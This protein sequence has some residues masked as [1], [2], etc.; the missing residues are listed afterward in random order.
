MELRHYLR[1]ARRRW[2]IA[3]VGM[4]T[5]ALAAFI[6]SRQLPPIYE[7]RATLLLNL[8]QQPSLP[9]YNDVSA[10]QALTKT[11][12]RLITSRP[13]LE[14]T[15]RRIGGAVTLEDLKRVSGTSE[16]QTQ[17][18]YVTFRHQDPALATT[19]VNTVA[20]V[21]AERI[22]TAQIGD[23]AP[24]G[25]SASPSAVNTIFI[26]DPAR[27][28]T[29]P[30]LPKV[31]LNVVLAMVAGLAIAIGIIAV[32]EYLD[33]AV[34]DAGDLQAIGLPLLGSLRQAGKRRDGA[35]S[36]LDDKAMKSAV[37]EDYRQLRTNLDFVAQPDEIRNILIT[38]VQ[39]ADGKTTVLCNLAIVLANTGRRVIVV[40]C[41]LRKPAVH[42]FFD[43]PN[44]SGLT[45]LFITDTRKLD[46]YLK[47][48]PVENLRILTSGP[49]TPP[50]PAQNLASPRMADIMS[51]L[52]SM[53]D[54]VL[55]DAPPVLGFS[56]AAVLA[57]RVNAAILV[58]H[59]GHTRPS[60][61]RLALELLQRSGVRLLGGVLNRTSGSESA[62][63]YYDYSPDYLDGRRAGYEA[64]A[65][66][67]ASRLSLLRRKL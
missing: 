23:T 13:V 47:V 50:D 29:T 6:V 17:L 63:Y 54:I 48:G 64:E 21:F 10:S 25:S 57:S 52:E 11:Y 24:G 12:A 55:Y 41:D 44:T 22:K 66:A 3:V 19:V 5:A 1:I 18:L 36:L 35:P 33:D 8:A 59:A 28:P 2:W 60:A 67:A 42:R 9:T 38:S 26:A 43:L 58:M 31:P 49:G 46:Q 32:L 40:D 45:T 15:V 56:E 37:G 61:V 39:P 7:A 20:Q 30:V 14:E 27:I 34:K 62:Y 51:R 53:A 65:R 16:P 4:V